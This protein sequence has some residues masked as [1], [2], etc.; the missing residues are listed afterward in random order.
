MNAAASFYFFLSFIYYIDRITF[1]VKMSFGYSVGDCIAI[2][3]LA[4]KVRERFN[5]APEQFKAISNESG[6]PNSH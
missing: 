4:N 2:L 1:T 5:D 3:Q 6:L